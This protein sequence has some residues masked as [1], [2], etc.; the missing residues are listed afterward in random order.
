MVVVQYSRYGG[1][2]TDC[3]HP[4]PLPYT[5]AIIEVGHQ[6]LTQ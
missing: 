5:Q 2:V 3:H 6:P 1:H 4:P